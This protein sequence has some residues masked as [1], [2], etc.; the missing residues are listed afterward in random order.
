MIDNGGRL[1]LIL[2]SRNTQ[3][4]AELATGSQLS[5]VE[6]LRQLTQL[7]DQGFVVAVHGAAALTVYRLS[8]KQVS[9]SELDPR[10]RILLIDDNADVQEI[11]TTVLEDDGY[12]VIATKTV[13]DAA[14]LLGQVTFDLVITDGFSQ[15]PGAV[16][17]NAADLLEAAD[18]TPVVL[19]TAH[20][21]EL[22][23]ALAAGFRDVIE[24]P[25][26]LEV[27]EQHVRALLEPLKDMEELLA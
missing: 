1:L 6:T 17:V 5:L 20:H 13:V 7:S 18:V 19:F 9:P 21:V 16:F 14:T 2:T 26:Q 24:K 8:P 22:D 3:T 27:L 12:V 11:V 4:A 23:A 25:F 15:T 10:Q